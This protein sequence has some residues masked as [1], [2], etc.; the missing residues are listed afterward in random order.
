MMEHPLWGVTAN[1][2][3]KRAGIEVTFQ[4]EKFP[5]LGGGEDANFCLQMQR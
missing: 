2:M 5:K 4:A 3:V 1:I